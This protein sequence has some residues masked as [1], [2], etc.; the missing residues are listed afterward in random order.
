VYRITGFETGAQKQKQVAK[1]KAYTYPFLLW[2]SS[3]N[4]KKFIAKIVLLDSSFFFFRQMIH[5]T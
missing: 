1:S 4:K 5:D 2:S 3:L